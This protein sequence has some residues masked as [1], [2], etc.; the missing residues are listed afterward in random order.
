MT[1][2]AA[3]TVSLKDKDILLSFEEASI[4][5]QNRQREVARYNRKAHEARRKLRQDKKKQQRAM[6]AA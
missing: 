3:R 4:A 1:I 6:M 2:T 5:S